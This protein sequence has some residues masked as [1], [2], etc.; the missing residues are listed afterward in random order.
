MSELG[1]QLEAD[2]PADLDAIKRPVELKNESPHEFKRIS[3][4]RRHYH[5]QVA[6]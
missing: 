1:K 4:R 3:G 6:M 5:S 2:K